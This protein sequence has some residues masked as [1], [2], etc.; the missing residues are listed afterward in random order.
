MKEA[1]D[2]EAE[3]DEALEQLRI[4]ATAGA[5]KCWMCEKYIP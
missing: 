3:R 5:F 2:A 1:A 4:A